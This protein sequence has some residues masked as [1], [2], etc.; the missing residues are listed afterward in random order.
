M[1]ASTQQY[2]SFTLKVALKKVKKKKEGN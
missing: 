2:L 1:P